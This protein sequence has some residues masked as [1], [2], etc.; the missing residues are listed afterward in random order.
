MD[1]VNDMKD[2]L[3][4]SNFTNKVI[5]QPEN[6]QPPGKPDLDKLSCYFNQSSLS[7]VEP[8]RTNNNNYINEKASCQ[9]NQVLD[10]AIKDVG[11]MITPEQV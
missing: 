3:E 6:I 5:N 4:V 7:A 2:N 9:D 1:T 10:N 11:E 8:G